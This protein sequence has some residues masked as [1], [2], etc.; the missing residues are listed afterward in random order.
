MTALLAHRIVPVGEAV[1][2][3]WVERYVRAWETNDPSQI[4]ALFAENASYYPAPH[5]EPWRG[6]AAIVANWLGRKDEPGSWSFRHE[7]VA[8][9]EDVTFVRGWTRYLD[10]PAD[11]SNLWVIRFN[12]SGQCVEFTEWWM[13]RDVIRNR[14]HVS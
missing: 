1:I 11:Y 12:D 3:A 8:V 6:R 4:G 14:N 9:A 5:E 13:E 2:A 10:P 7:I